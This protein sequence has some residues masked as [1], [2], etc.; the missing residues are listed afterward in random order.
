MSDTPAT[1][2]AAKEKAPAKGPSESKYKYVGPPLRKGL[3][4]PNGK[5]IVPGQI[6]DS[7]LEYYMEQFPDLREYFKV[8]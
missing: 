2:P 6:A 1:T 7:D 4:L 3:N 5:L 8:G